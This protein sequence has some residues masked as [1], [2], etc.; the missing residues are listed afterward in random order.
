[1]P[2]DARGDREHALVDL[3]QPPGLHQP[4]S[5]ARTVSTRRCSSGSPIAA[6]TSFARI[7]RPALTIITTTCSFTG[8][9]FC[10][11]AL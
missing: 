3:G 11:S 10:G 7:G 9:S 1:V 6:A 2:V 4:L 8:F 5:R